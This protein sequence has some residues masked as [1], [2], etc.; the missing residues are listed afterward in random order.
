MAAV[1]LSS[2][3]AVA[4]MLSAGLAQ[5][6]SAPERYQTAERLA[7]AHIKTF[8]TL[9]FDVFS[10]HKWDRLKESHAQDI[11]VRWPD[12]RETHGIKQ[13]IEDLKAMFVYAPAG[14]TSAI[15]GV[16]TR[17]INEYSTNRQGLS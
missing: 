16:E 9:D 13:R 11:V 8:D 7:E 14:E 6:E 15:Y 10:N 3:G 5:A 1:L 17:P 12:G 4:L 2:V